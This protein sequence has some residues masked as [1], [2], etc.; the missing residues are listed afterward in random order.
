MLP[1]TC[2][3]ALEL[4]TCERNGQERCR[5]CRAVVEYL[6]PHDVGRA[7]GLQDIEILL[8]VERLEVGKRREALLFHVGLDSRVGLPAVRRDLVAA[9]VNEFVREDVL[10]A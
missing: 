8:L 3:V 5:S 1:R 4:G 6:L 7:L 10:K 9:D 2:G